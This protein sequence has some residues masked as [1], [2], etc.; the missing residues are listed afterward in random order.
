MLQWAKRSPDEKVNVFSPVCIVLPSVS[1]AYKLC[2]WKSSLSTFQLLVLQLEDGGMLVV[3]ATLTESRNDA[4]LP[5]R[6]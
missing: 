1:V 4:H 5:E 6:A 2:T 3:F